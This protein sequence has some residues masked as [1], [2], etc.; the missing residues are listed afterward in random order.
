V[1]LSAA[2][3][4]EPWKTTGSGFIA[5]TQGLD[6]DQRNPASRFLLHVL[7]AAA[8]FE[9]SFI[10]E[11]TQAGRLRYRQNFDTGK[12]G[13]TVH[14]RYLSS[15]RSLKHGLKHFHSGIGSQ[16]RAGDTLRENQAI[17]QLMVGEADIICHLDD[18]T[19][20]VGQARGPVPLSLSMSVWALSSERVIAPAC[21]GHRIG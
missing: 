1:P 10:R 21:F 8:E 9:R 13:K 6:T 20:Q 3:T 11:R 2:P 17:Q 12:V 7:G 16:M 15:S 5:V 14:S 4:S 18:E 19:G